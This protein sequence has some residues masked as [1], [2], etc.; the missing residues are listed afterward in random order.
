MSGLFLQ[1]KTVATASLA[2]P[3]SGRICVIRLIR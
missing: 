3:R 2:S 1:Y